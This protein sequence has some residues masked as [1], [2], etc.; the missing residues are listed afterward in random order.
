MQLTMGLGHFDLQF[1]PL[2]RRDVNFRGFAGNVYTKHYFKPYIFHHRFRYDDD[3]VFWSKQKR[4]SQY[5][6]PCVSEKQVVNTLDFDSNPCLHCTYY[7]AT[8]TEVKCSKNTLN[9]KL[10]VSCKYNVAGDCLNVHN[11]ISIL[12]VNPKARQHRRLY[13]F[14]VDLRVGCACM[15]LTY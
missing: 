3:E 11:K 14:K 2:V 4:T 10:P 15:L 7:P 1:C 9:D 5:K 12:R 8:L 13:T 6:N